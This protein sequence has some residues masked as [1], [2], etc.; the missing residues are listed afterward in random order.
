MPVG[1]I[2]TYTRNPITGADANAYAAFVMAQISRGAIG[3][4]SIDVSNVG[5][6]INVGLGMAGIDDGTGNGRGT[7]QVTT[8]GSVSTG[9]G[10]AGVWHALEFS[11]SGTAVTF[12][13]TALA[14]E[15][16]ESFMS[17]TM[18]G[19]YDAAKGGYYR[20]AS[21]RVLAFVFLRAALVVGRIVNTENGVIGF[22]GIKIVDNRVMAGTIGRV[23][24]AQSCAE[25]GVWNMQ[26]AGGG[27]DVVLVVMPTRALV[28]P[29]V[30]SISAVI[31]G[32]DAS[33]PWS[34]D[35]FANGADPNLRAGGWDLASAATTRLYRRTGG[36]FDNV[37]FSSVLVN[38]GFLQM[39][40]ET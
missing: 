40:W 12:Y 22:K 20:I 28:A 10:T 6:S 19:Y 38:R 5:G 14:G 13:L 1:I 17:L 36:F 24:I 30:I 32:D 37:N 11:V 23:Y 35:K 7:I 15:F 8:A 26:A 25:I 33:G 34:I 2:A 31:Y 18:K 4:N 9:G 3:A 29:K 39:Q 27:G 16:D 21:R